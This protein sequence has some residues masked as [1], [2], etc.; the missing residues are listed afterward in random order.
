[1][2]QPALC[3]GSCCPV[4]RI[5][6]IKPPIHEKQFE[7]LLF[8]EEAGSHRSRCWKGGYRS[9]ADSRHSRGCWHRKGRL[10]SRFAAGER[11][12]GGCLTLLSP[13]GKPVMI[14]PIW[15]EARG[16]AISSPLNILLV[17]APG[18][19]KIKPMQFSGVRGGRWSTA[20]W[21]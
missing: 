6:N 14:E 13:C 5:D 18:A 21:N 4:Q 17:G 7:I 16:V 20:R 1:M 19:C 3:W 12:C 10:G 15:K 9:A 11:C 2:D 8:L